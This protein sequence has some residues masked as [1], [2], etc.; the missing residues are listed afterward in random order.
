MTTNQTEPAADCSSS[1]SSR[2]DA[3]CGERA[4]TACHKSDANTRLGEQQDRDAVDLSESEPEPAAAAAAEPE[5]GHSQ[6]LDVAE[7]SGVG[8]SIA[9]NSANSSFSSCSESQEIVSSSSSSR[10]SSIR[11]DQQQRIE[12]AA[13]AARQQ[14]VSYDVDATAVQSACSTCALMHTNHVASQHTHMHQD[15]HVRAPLPTA[16]PNHQQQPSIVYV[17]A[18]YY[19]TQYA[20]APQFTLVPHFASRQ[21]PYTS[22]VA[23]QQHHQQP[24]RFVAPQTAAYMSV[25]PHAM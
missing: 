17:P 6:Q 23:T 20:S 16:H 2:C 1:S 12:N 19:A 15:P 18:Q 22:P 25:H 9:S 8:S 11:S 13:I 14:Q 21:H 4:A 24:H 5:A 3:C 7:S 10:R